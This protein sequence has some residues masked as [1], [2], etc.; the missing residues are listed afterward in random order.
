MND[1][2]NML[3]QR[4]GGIH[5][6]GANADGIEAA[7]RNFQ[8]QLAKHGLSGYVEQADPPASGCC[9]AAFHLH[10][11][12]AEQ[13]T[14][15]CDTLQLCEKLGFDTRNNADELEREILLTILASPVPF[16]FPSHDELVSAIRIRKSIVEAARRT[17]LAFDTSAAERPTDF[18]TYSKQH[19][20]TLLPGK[21]LIAA[22]KA[23]TQPNGSGKVFSFSCYRA[24]EYVILLSV[25]Q[26]AMHCNPELFQGLQRQW[27][28]RAIMS[29]EF[30][31]VFLRE[32]GSMSEPLPPKYYVP[33]DR[34]WFRNPDDHSS[35]VTGYEGSW[36]LY[37]G[38][39]LF[40][41]FWKQ[42][43]PYTLTTKCVE[44]FHW[45][46]ATYHDE[47]GELQIDETLVEQL[48][49]TSMN[50][51]A[52]I[53]KILDTMLRFREPAGVYIDGGCIDT[54]RECP[55]WVCPE[56]S[57]LRLPAY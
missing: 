52:E 19:G 18:W 36:V 45:R 28:S 46:N 41:N 32:Y 49:R 14:P 20:F 31:D 48:V 47:T 44:L 1:R 21:P 42:D 23:S 12:Y 5:F 2:N 27:E 39:G 54:S 17:T 15:E 55:R 9:S 40:T 13:W 51:P 22:L 4:R 11:S 33:G 10:R 35:D 29:G 3:D 6:R 57:D 16:S 30:H 7:A 50:D 26:E 34:V 43:E 24:T 8:H 37:L 56:T 25:A 38:G 53:R